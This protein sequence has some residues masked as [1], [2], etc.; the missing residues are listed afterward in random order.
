M[1]GFLAACVLCALAAAA[2][3]GEYR[4]IRNFRDFSAMAVDRKLV[5]GDD[6][7]R[8]QA[9]GRIVGSAG[10]GDVAGRWEWS[11]GLLCRSITIRDRGQK[12]D[13]LLIESDGNRLRMLRDRG[14]G[15]AEE[16]TIARIRKSWKK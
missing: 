13:C 8:L 7:I 3:A 9:D 6:W 5:A 12:P 14:R 2:E 15:Q 4:A 10:G 1:K 16:F 11:D